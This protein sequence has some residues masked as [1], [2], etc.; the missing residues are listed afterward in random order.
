VLL[1]TSRPE[2][3]ITAAIRRVVAE[4]ARVLNAAS[5]I[6][7]IAV[8]QSVTSGDRYLGDSLAPTRFA[9]AL[10]VAF[11]VVAIVL[12]TVGLYGVIAYGVSQRTRE[13]GVRL[14]LGARAQT[15]AVMVVGGGLRLAAAGIVIGV[16]A[17]A[18][19]TRL[20]ESLLYGVTPADPVT[21]ATIAS[22]VAAIALAASYVPA[23]RA[24]RV[25]PTQALRA[26]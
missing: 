21:F 16:A 10:L 24:V 15:V 5:G 2:R 19:A 18:A 1:R 4:F 3:E 7:T 22:V 20:L 14:A 11:A 6:P 9:M 23:R 17:A 8:V 25:D 12:T 13:L 26:D